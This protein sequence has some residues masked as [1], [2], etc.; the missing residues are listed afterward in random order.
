MVIIGGDRYNKLE[1]RSFFSFDF[2]DAEIKSRPVT[3]WR[4][5]MVVKWL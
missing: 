2:N 5:W 1:S 3:R 4:L